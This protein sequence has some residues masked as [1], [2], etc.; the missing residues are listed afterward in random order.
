MAN[1]HMN[2]MLNITNYQRNANHNNGI[3]FQTNKT[4]YHHKD[5][6][7]QKLMRIWRIMY[8]C[9]LLWEYICIGNMENVIELPPKTNKQ[10]KKVERM[11]HHI[12]ILIY[13]FMLIYTTDLNAT[14]G[15]LKIL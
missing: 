8:P 1:R 10:K 7:S 12:K 14:L 15:L 4:D 2:K 13:A 3:S 9:A 5:H 6:M 11:D